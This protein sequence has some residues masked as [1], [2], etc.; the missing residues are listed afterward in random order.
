M[1]EQAPAP[2]GLALSVPVGPHAHEASNAAA[3]PA[4]RAGRSWKLGIVRW[5]AASQERKSHPVHS[6]QAARNRTSHCQVLRNLS[7][8]SIP[9]WGAPNGELGSR[10]ES[11]CFRGSGRPPA[12]LL[13]IWCRPLPEVTASVAIRFAITTPGTSPQLDEPCETEEPKCPSVVRS[14]TT[15]RRQSAW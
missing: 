11:G 9:P 14:A 12:V 10:N 13:C 2:T 6:V 3:L 7:W 15:P 5:R 4:Y 8:R 1:A